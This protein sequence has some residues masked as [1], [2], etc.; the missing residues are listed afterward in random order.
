MER[1]LTGFCEAAR[2]RSTFVLPRRT[3]DPDGGRGGGWPTCPRARRRAGQPDSR[4]HLIGPV[5]PG[6]AERW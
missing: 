2:G 4:V 6:S 3:L 1:A 5:G